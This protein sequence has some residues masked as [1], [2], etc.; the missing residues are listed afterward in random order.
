MQ[1]KQCSHSDQRIGWMR[2]CFTGFCPLED[3][4]LGDGC[5][6]QHCCQATWATALCCSDPRLLV[7]VALSFQ[8]SYIKVPTSVYWSFGL[9]Y[10]LLKLHYIMEFP[11]KLL[12][13][14]LCPS[15][16]SLSLALSFSLNPRDDFWFNCRATS[17][18]SF[19][20]QAS[21][22]LVLI[23]VLDTWVLV[24][25]LTIPELLSQKLPEKSLC[26]C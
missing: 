1:W 17:R 24:K 23:L 15:L 20:Y 11:M 5:S 14:F 9:K 22:I 18:P 3:M 12:I 19:C 7:M 10:G 21:L 4:S 25:G 26:S 13:P 8:H 16:F 2:H 6:C